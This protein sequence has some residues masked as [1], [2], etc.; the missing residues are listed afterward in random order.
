MDLHWVEVPFSDLTDHITDF[1]LTRPRDIYPGAHKKHWWSALI[2]LRDTSINEFSRQAEAAVPG[3]LL[4]PNDYTPAERAA[5]EKQQLVTIYARTSLLRKINGNANAFGVASVVLGSITPPHHLDFNAPDKQKKAPVIRVDSG[6]VVMAVIDDGIAFANNLFRS[7]NIT[8]RVEHV[9][10]LSAEPGSGGKRVNVGR[11]L[12]KPEIDELLAS[13]TT[14]QLLDE[15]LFYRKAGLIDYYDRTFSPAGLRT[16]HGTHVMGLAAGHAMTGSPDNRPIICAILPSRVTEDVSGQNL[17][18]SLALALKRLK[19][20]A[21]RFQLPDGEPAPVVFNFSYGNFAGPHDGTSNIDRLIEQYFQDPSGQTMRMVLPAGNGNLTRT[22]AR[23]TLDPKAP[24]RTH[25]LDLMALPDNRTASHIEM[26][27]PFCE[28]T[29]ARKAA[30]VRVTPPGGPE[31]GPVSP[32]GETYQMLID[33]SGREIARLSYRLAPAPTLRGVIVLS[34]NPTANLNET[35]LAPSGTWKIAVTPHE[36]EPDKKI[37]VWVVRDE[38]LPGF[39]PAGRQSYFDNAC[40][41]R[42]DSLGGPLAVDPP[43]TDCPVRRA[44]TLSG[45]ACGSAPL[46]VAALTQSNGLLSDYSAAGPITPERDKAVANR[47]GPDASAKGDDSPVLRGVL[48]A[49]SRSGSMV[50]LNGTSVAAPRVARFTSAGLA[51]GA[52]GDRC[53]LWS[54][55][56]KE[57]PLFPGQKPGVTRTGGGRLD[58]PVYLTKVRLFP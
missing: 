38:T 21:A 29:P 32:P 51:S 24:S 20:Q 25:E 31:S 16:S 6:T 7:S 34:F 13:C 46:V 49:G 10:I 56:E 23:I 47:L 15:E 27:M 14:C 18:P 30:S 12:A 22:H 43:D 55:A 52:N 4:I 54:E 3:T 17:L 8:S 50:R 42:F 44:G 37:E 2:D 41:R 57:D 28:Q 48:S 53:W 40:Y 39:R 11:A 36:H 5:I 9:S 58:I 45:F 1:R 33:G 19:R 35:A 26:W